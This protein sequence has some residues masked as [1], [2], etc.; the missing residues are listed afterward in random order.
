M[1]NLY[2]P[3]KTTPQ[4]T[5]IEIKTEKKITL[6]VEILDREYDICENTKLWCSGKKGQWGK[7]LINSVE[8]PKKVE[9]TGLL[10]E[11]AFAKVFGLPIDIEYCEGGKHNDF[12]SCSKKI[13]IKTASKKPSYNCGLVRYTK[14]L[15]ADI[16]VFN[17]IEEDNREQKKA[18][19]ILVGWD[20]KENVIKQKK[21][22]AKIGSHMNYEIEYIKLIPINL[23]GEILNRE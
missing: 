16:Y 12:L 6:C 2:Y 14:Q 18:K 13:D 3:Q 17:Y 9:R 5:F 22:K 19:I 10:G 23:L 21:N 11:M 7:G 15:S 20:Y 1:T 8:D 4:E